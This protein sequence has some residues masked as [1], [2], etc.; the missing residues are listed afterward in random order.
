MEL[1][2]SP[3]AVVGLIVLILIFLTSIPT[4]LN[5][6]KRVTSKARS[7]P[8]DETSKLYR[9]EDGIATEESQREFSAS[10]PKYIALSCSLLGFS[11]SIS[12][13]IFSTV[14]PASNLCVEY[15]LSFGTWAC[16]V[17]Q[18][19]CVVLERCSVK[20]YD[21]G[22]LTALGYALLTTTT[23]TRMMIHLSYLSSLWS[24]N[25]FLGSDV[26]QVCAA[27]ISFVACLSLPRRPDVEDGGTLVDGQYTVSA[28]GRYS[29]SWAGSTLVSARKKKTFGLDD[30]PK[31]HVE[32]RSAYLEE[33]FRTIEIIRDHL[34]KNLVFAHLSELL[35]QTALTIFQSAAQFL[36]QLVMYCFLKRLESRAKGDSADK[37]TWGLV[38]ALGIVTMA[39]SWIKHWLY[40]VVWARLGQPLRT[41]LSVMIFGKAT[42]R[43]DVKSMQKSEQ[44]TDAN[45][46][47]E[48]TMSAANSGS[49]DQG[50]AET[51]SIPGSKPGQAEQVK[52]EDAPEE[53]VQKS[54]QS[55]INL[56]VRFAPFTT[57]TQHR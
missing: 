4:F 56:V 12:I 43:K 32:G 8:L 9:D 30:L 18:T 6:Y 15:W 48:P 39:S 14:H 50:T 20:R 10:V 55:T 3:S 2:S 33:K 19:I 47:S 27:V 13:A 17:L 1:S 40:F 46:V 5:I 57:R 16:V 42:R 26:I 37:A 23:C 52:A 54:R 24:Y 34:W 31:L 53:D 22:C 38:A 25:T 36:P 35:F 44:T 11:A 29:F 51:H 7:A 49:D 45:T 41:E 28:L 21:Y